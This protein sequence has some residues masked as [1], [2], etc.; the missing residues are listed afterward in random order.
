MT[1][2]LANISFFQDL[3]SQKRSKA[4]A[5]CSAV[6]SST[7]FSQVLIVG[8]GELAVEHLL[9]LTHSGMEIKLAR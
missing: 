9:T 3:Q 8:S 6:N 4:M 7:G 5:R 2:D 1:C